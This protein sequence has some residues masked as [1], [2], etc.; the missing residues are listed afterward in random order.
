[1]SQCCEVLIKDSFPNINDDIYQYVESVLQ[2]ALD[3]FETE[4][5]V[6][7]AIGEV[8]QEVEADK[9]EDDVRD[10]C[11]QVLNLLKPDAKK[12][13]NGVQKMLNAPVQ[14]G[15][16]AT[17][18]GVEDTEDANSIWLKNSSDTNRNVDAKKLA[19]SQT[20]GARGE[21]ETAKSSKDRQ[22][23]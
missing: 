18:Q 15:E 20:E 19:K 14:L 5:D 1:M 3:D 23:S 10:I 17:T 13:T 12:K 21:K 16:L 6:Y 4:E 7:E 2:N 8:L 22:T 11:V 9:T